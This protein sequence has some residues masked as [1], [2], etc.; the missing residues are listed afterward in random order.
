MKVKINVLNHDLSRLTVIDEYE[1]LFF[2]RKYNDVGE[3]ILTINLASNQAHLLGMGAFI[4]IG[5][6]E[7]KIGVIGNITMQDNEDGTSLIIVK[8]KTLGIILNWREIIPRENESSITYTGNVESV[9]HYYVNNHCI[10]PFDAS[11]KVPILKASKDNKTGSVIRWVSKQARLLDEIKIISEIYQYGWQ[12]KA[13]IDSA[14]LIY[15]V[16][17]GR[18]LTIDNEEGNSPVIFS[19]KFENIF[20]M[21]YIQ[22]NNDERT[23]AY[24][25]LDNSGAG[26]KLYE[27]SRVSGF[28]RKEITLQVASQ[29]DNE[30][31]DV[32]ERSDALLK[33]YSK[34]KT[35]DAEIRDCKMFKFEQDYDLGDEV[36]VFN[37]TWN[38]K[39]NM[40]IISIAETY[41]NNGCTINARFGSRILSIIDKLKRENRVYE[42]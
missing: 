40:R 36:T 26:R 15:D 22:D 23:F 31:I 12:I 32:P 6:D 41:D 9:L 29:E 4:M 42:I 24:T 1:S 11:R 19:K 35:V 17:K 39:E 25:L 7:R 33:E 38:M 8:G 37:E 18:N 13:D 20:R 16:Y 14:K 10:N 5:S 30:Y 28:D 21:E 27:S 34:I 2:E 3:F